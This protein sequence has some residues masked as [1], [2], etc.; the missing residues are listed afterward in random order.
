MKD[1]IDIYNGVDSENNYVDMAEA[2][3]NYTLACIIQFI[4]AVVADYQATKKEAKL[5]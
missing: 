3:D 2:L 1:I 5:D 4:E